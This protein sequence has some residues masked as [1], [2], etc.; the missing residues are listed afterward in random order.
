[1]TENTVTLYYNIT[2]TQLPI[3]HA[4]FRTLTIKG[5]SATVFKHE[6]KSDA[7]SCPENLE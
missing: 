3:L 5:E 4:H 2:E 6:T 7:L 1:M